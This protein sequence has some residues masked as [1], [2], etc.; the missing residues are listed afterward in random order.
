RLSSAPPLVGGGFNDVVPVYPAEMFDPATNSW[1]M[2][3]SQRSFRL[4]HSTAVLLPDGTVLSSGSNFNN[5]AEIYRPGYLFRG[6]RPIITSPPGSIRYSH[7]FT[8]STNLATSI[9][10]VVLLRPGAATHAFNQDQR[11]V[12]L[13]FVVSGG[14]LRVDAPTNPNVAPPGIYMLFILNGQGVPSVAS[15][16]ELKP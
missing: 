5:T 11:Y 6:P 14:G 3:A 12:P 7:N 15:F 8:V 10:S 4:Y 1:S 16:V 9:T 13:S 2:M